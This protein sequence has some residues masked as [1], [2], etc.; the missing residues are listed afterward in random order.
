MSSPVLSSGTSRIWI[1]ASAPPSTASPAT[2]ETG[3][4]WMN[5][6]LNNL[7]ICTDEDPDALVWAQIY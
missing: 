7:Y 2:Y 4:F 1:D 3:N 5:T 6:D